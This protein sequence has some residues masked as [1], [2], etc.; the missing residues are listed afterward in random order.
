MIIYGWLG[1]PTLL[2]TKNDLCATCGVAGP[3]MIVRVVRWATL[4]WAPF[5]PIWISHKLV[6]GNCGAETKLGWRQTRAGLKSGKLPLPHRA[7]F[8]AYATKVLDE[9]NRRPAESEFD[10][11]TKNPK[12]DAWDLWLK[13]WP[14]VVA[15]LIAAVA[16]WP[17]PAPAPPPPTVTVNHTCWIATDGSIAG[18]RL[19]DGTVIGEAA[20]TQ[21]VCYFT[22]PFPTGNETIRCKN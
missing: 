18:C 16:F 9:T 10:P 7:G 14:I 4:F 5:L 21:T 8:D 13:A 11:I 15:L 17:R 20:G 12:R 6:C 1:R 19:A 2:G 3:H 22:E